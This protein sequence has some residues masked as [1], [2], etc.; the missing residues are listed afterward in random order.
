MII[1]HATNN[2]FLFL[3]IKN[4]IFACFHSNRNLILTLTFKIFV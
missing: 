2:K 4:A 3:E 1:M